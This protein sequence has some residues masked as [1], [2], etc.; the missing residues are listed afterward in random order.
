MNTRYIE[1]DST[2]RDRSQYPFPGDFIVQ[3]S[4]EQK[5]GLKALDPVSD[6]APIATWCSNEF[7]VGG[8]ATVSTTV[9]SVS[10]DRTTFLVSSATGNLQQIN[11]YYLNAVANNTTLTELQRIT[12][13][14]FLG[15]VAAGTEQAEITVASSF[16]SSFAVGDTVTIS[17]GTNIVAPLTNPLVFVPNGERGENA[18]N[19][20]LLYDETVG[21]SRPISGYSA[22]THL[23]TLDTSGGAVTGW[24]NTDC[25]SIRKILPILRGVTPA[26]PPNNTTTTVLLPVTASSVDNFYVGDYLR[27]SGIT[28]PASAPDNEMR[29]IK[30]YDGTTRV[31][32]LV[33]GFSAI[34]AN[35]TDIVEILKFS[36]D[37]YNSFDYTGSTVSQS[38]S[39]CYEIELINL[40]LPNTTLNVGQGGKPIFYPFFYVKF[41]GVSASDGK[42]SGTIYSNNP[43]SKKALFKAS[44]DDNTNFLTSPFI[45]LDSDGMKQTVKFKPN[46]TLHFAVYLP[47]GDIFKTV[48]IDTSA[49]VAPNRL[50]QITALFSIRRL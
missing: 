39:V 8:G 26:G 10:S 12:S 30:A 1:L 22:E 7:K 42:T 38:N 15:E 21:D 50:L 13:Y 36:H 5:I 19:M 40:T 33:S 27:V 16:G 46:D 41:D 47:N 2:Y 17:D 49:P 28:I 20:Y 3:M 48:E 31:A 37:N 43:N 6:A 32:T 25:F 18:Y 34:P 35:G 4:Q 9:T 23:L 14:T 11:D 29:Q 24:A 45:K 44:S